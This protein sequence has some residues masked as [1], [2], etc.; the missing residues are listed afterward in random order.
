MRRPKLHF[1]GEPDRFSSMHKL[2]TENN[3]VP[4]WRVRFARAVDKKFRLSRLQAQADRILSKGRA[5]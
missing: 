4:G 2:F 1:D 5:A 3:F